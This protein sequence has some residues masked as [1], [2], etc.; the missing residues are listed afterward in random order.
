MTSY[1]RNQETADMRYI[2]GIANGRTV[3]AR[4][5][6]IVLLTRKDIQIKRYHLHTFFKT[7]TPLR[8]RFI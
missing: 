3:V 1:Y 7:L 8:N 6:I 4:K 5:F 2:Y